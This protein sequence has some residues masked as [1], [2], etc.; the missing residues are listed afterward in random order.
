[1]SMRESLNL[2]KYVRKSQNVQDQYVQQGVI[3]RK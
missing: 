3:G 1:M 2:Q